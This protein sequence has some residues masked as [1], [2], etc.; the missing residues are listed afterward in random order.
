MQQRG[1]E[2]ER[3]SRGD[4]GVSEGLGS[5]E[6]EGE[7]KGSCIVEERGKGRLER[8][9]GAWRSEGG[10]LRG[11]GRTG[12]VKERPQSVNGK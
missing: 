3:G 12:G 1:G 2:G 4:G 7:K 5:R 6:K 8:G 10:G 9:D 11:N